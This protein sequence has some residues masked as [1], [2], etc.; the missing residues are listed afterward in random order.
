MRARV[1]WDPPRPTSADP[2]CPRARE[3]AIGGRRVQAAIQPGR[4]QKPTAAE[5]KS[6]KRESLIRHF[7]V[8]RF[9]KN[10]RTAG[11]EKAAKRRGRLGAPVSGQKWPSWGQK[12][13]QKGVDFGSQTPSR[14]SKMT[15]Q[16]G[17]LFSG[18]FLNLQMASLNFCRKS[19]SPSG[20]KSAFL[21]S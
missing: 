5:K 11:P 7:G 2:F 15:P 1:R 18:R 4:A 3:A 14:G 12:R 21:E 19:S 9:Q 13:G 16:M 20:P 8:A 17:P 10:R 6:K